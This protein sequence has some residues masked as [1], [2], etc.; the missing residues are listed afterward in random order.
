MLKN[1]AKILT[2]GI[3]L[4]VILLSTLCMGAYKA[5]KIT[6]TISGSVGISGVVMSGLPGNPVTG[7]NGDYTATVEYG[8]KG[9]VTPTKEGY[10]F[11]PVSRT[12]DK[13]TSNQ[14]NQSYTAAIITFTISGTAGQ[15]GVTMNGLPGMPVTDETGRYTATVNYGWTGTITPTKE[16]YVFQPAD[17]KIDPV[18]TKQTNQDYSAK[19][20]TFTISGS[21]GMDGVVM[22]GLP[23]NPV[24]SGG[25]LYT[26]TVEYNWNGTVTPTK[27]GYTFE[28]VNKTYDKVT[29]NQANQG[30]SAKV[31]T[32]TI[33]GTTGQSGVVMNGL[34]GNPVTNEKG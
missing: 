33:S 17:R 19:V 31:I 13:V 7:N 29:G 15:S 34:P 20:R 3:T 26:A 28:P 8:W 4:F 27:E 21:A 25:G 12:Y 9:T 5:A 18:T 14:V 10:T 23:G 30:Y 1:R 24:T 2:V 16:G 22:N 11:E 32:L 6:D